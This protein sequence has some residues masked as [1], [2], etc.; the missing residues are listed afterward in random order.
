MTFHVFGHVKSNELNAH[1][2]RHLFGH[3][4]LAYPRRAGKQEGTN[5]FVFVPQS[6]AGQLDRR[7]EAGNGLIL[8]INDQL[9][10]P[11]QIA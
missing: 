11:F 1:D 6:G 7:R 3:F 4:G 10:I 9:Q 8:T 5:G 2:A